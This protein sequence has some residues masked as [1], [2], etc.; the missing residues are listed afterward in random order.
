VPPFDLE[1]IDPTPAAVEKAMAE[2]VE[3][4]NRRCSVGVMPVDRGNYRRFLSAE[5]A[6]APEGVAIWLADKGRVETFPPTP[7]AT[8]LGVAWHTT[9]LG[10]RTVRVVGRRIEPFKESSSNRFGPPWRPW[11]ALCHLDPDHV[12]TRTLA[13]GEPEAIALCGCGAVGRPEKLAWMGGRCGPCHDHLEEHGTP[14]AVEDGPPVLRTTGQLIEVGF[15]PSGRSVAAVEWV[16]T[17]QALK[18]AV[19]DRA[20]GTCRSELPQPTFGGAVP[21]AHPATGL[22]LSCSDFIFCV[23][24]AGQGPALGLRGPRACVAIAFHGTRGAAL[25]YNGEGWRR[26]LTAEEDWESCWPERR[27]G[28]DVIYSAVAFAPGGAKVALGR[29]GSAVELLDWPAGSGPTLQ[30]AV[31][32]EAVADQR[33]YALAFSPDGKLLAAG[34][35]LSG[36]VD[37]PRE[38]W[39]GREGGLF[40]YDAVK[41][42]F[43]ASFLAPKDD[44]LAVAFA[45]DGSLLFYGSTDCTI[46]VLDLTMREEVAVLSGHVGGVNALA[47]SLDGSTLASAGGDGL[48]RLWPWRQLVARQE[49]RAPARPPASAGQ[50]SG[51]PRMPGDRKPRRGK[52]AGG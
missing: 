36:F 50:R 25:S 26:D 14:L 34:T 49:D 9:P 42:E 3:T 31:A 15:L 10:R 23:G 40:L 17:G 22:T 27:S 46:R 52:G 20:T 19:W 43:L 5:F 28:R 18:V 2:A 1:L 44:I 6:A 24:E 21:P 41:G 16:G 39:R 35:G 11:P 7:R 29:T 48:V 33:V 37:D 51:G 8:L 30:P 47:F 12:V 38:E 13:G 4:A 45:P 32:G